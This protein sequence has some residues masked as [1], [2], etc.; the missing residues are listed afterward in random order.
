MPG[1]LSK[2]TMGLDNR[3]GIFCSA[4]RAARH[5]AERWTPGGRAGKRLDTPGSLS[6][7]TGMTWSVRSLTASLNGSTGAPDAKRRT[8]FRLIR[9]KQPPEGEGQAEEG[10]Q[11]GRE[12]G[13]LPRVRTDLCQRCHSAPAAK[14][15][16][17]ITYR[18][19]SSNA[20]CSLAALR[21]PSSNHS[22]L[23]IL[24]LKQKTQWSETNKQR[25][26]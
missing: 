15:A 3:T 8:F 13:R 20:S 18:A 7:R 2:W 4:L 23:N 9:G 12:H 19:M 1:I 22:K 6:V 25:A 14:Q 26:P 11:C 24:G 16:M 10:W 21:K 17:A 5:S